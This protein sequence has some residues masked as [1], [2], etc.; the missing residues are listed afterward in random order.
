MTSVWLRVLGLLTAHMWIGAVATAWFVAEGRATGQPIDVTLR[1]VVTTTDSLPTGLGL[2]SVQ[3]LGT[4]KAVMAHNGEVLFTSYASSRH[5]TWIETSNGIEAVQVQGD[6]VP[7]Y[8]LLSFRSRLGRPR[9]DRAGQIWFA[10]EVNGVDV[11]VENRG[12]LWRGR[13]GSLTIVARNGDPAPVR[14]GPPSAYA[15][16]GLHG[17]SIHGYAQV[18]TGLA[19][20]R[21]TL[22]NNGAV[23]LFGPNGEDRQLFRLGDEPPGTGTGTI[24]SRASGTSAST[25]DGLALIRAEI[26]GTGVTSAN[27]RVVWRETP[28]ATSMVLRPYFTQAPGFDE[29]TTFTNGFIEFDNTLR[30]GILQERLVGPTITTQND[31]GIWSFF[32]GEISEIVREGD[33]IDPSDPT[34]RTHGDTIRELGS[35]VWS[36]NTRGDMIVIAPTVDAQGVQRYSLLLGSKDG[37]QVLLDM[38]SDAPILGPGVKIDWA[39]GWALNEVGQ[40]MLSV[41]LSGPN[42]TVDNDKAILVFN[43]DGG[44]AVVARKGET[45]EYRPGQFGVLTNMP[46]DHQYTNI[47]ARA[48]N[49]RGEIVFPVSLDGMEQALLVA[50][51]QA[52]YADCDQSTGAGILDIFDFLCFQDRFVAGSAKACDCDTST[53][54]GVCDL[55]DF[56][57]F[58][59]AF[60][61]GCS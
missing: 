4:S 10:A 32:D 26:S 41:Q 6:P 43:P 39:I 40:V 7:G 29:P 15:G 49:D 42:V 36:V 55:F 27:R 21:V 18:G 5:G 51:V 16:L 54:A 60:V 17:L 53:G 44:V 57:C 3:S 31:Q 35:P 24:Y 58:Q 30:R 9:I 22:A 28:G 2:A 38:E 59:N 45:I 50:R 25:A 56:L 34:S 47:Y 61:S 52:C 12:I 46:G 19:G 13:P 33:H 20:P 8:P 23:F 14:T 48:F 1:T 11:T 37:F